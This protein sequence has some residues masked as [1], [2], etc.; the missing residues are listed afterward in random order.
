MQLYYF[1]EIMPYT[2]TRSVLNG[3]SRRDIPDEKSIDE[4]I[5]VYLVWYVDIR[6]TIVM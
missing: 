4:D 1:V 6:E 5:D 3:Y 2:L